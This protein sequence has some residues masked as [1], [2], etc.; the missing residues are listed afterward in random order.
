MNLGRLTSEPSSRI[1]PVLPEVC[2]G[3][4]LLKNS[5]IAPTTSENVGPPDTFDS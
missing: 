3:P 5:D 1:E 4:G 2:D